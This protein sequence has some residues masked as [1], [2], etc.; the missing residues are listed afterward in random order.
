MHR[1]VLFL[2]KIKLCDPSGICLIL[3]RGA[4]G[5]DFEG[6]PSLHSDLLRKDRERSGHRQSHAFARAFHLVL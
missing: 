6:N 5:G 2:S 3:V 1:M 4:S